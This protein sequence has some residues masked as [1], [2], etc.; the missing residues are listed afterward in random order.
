MLQ[1]PAIV[2][3]QKEHDIAKIIYHINQVRTYPLTAIEIE[4]WSRSINE[5]LPEL[6]LDNLRE[7]V[8]EMKK[9]NIEYDNTRGIQNIFKGLNRLDMRGIV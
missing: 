5:I 6:E 4:D 2:L 1:P 9:G 7:L 8:V 3:S